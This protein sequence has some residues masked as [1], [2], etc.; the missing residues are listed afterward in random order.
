MD[1]TRP[2]LEKCAMQLDNM[3]FSVEDMADAVSFGKHYY[4]RIGTDFLKDT[5]YSELDPADTI[6]QNIELAANYTEDFREYL[7]EFDAGLAKLI[8][9][10]GKLAEEVGIPM[11]SHMG[12]KKFARHDKEYTL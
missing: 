4:D 7:Q 1:K 8:E 10:R 6:E 11:M 3:K 5:M 12:T 9:L 2:L